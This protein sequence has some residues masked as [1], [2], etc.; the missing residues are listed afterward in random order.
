MK[1]IELDYSKRCAGEPTKGTTGGILIFHRLLRWPP[2]RGSAPDQARRGR[3]GL[4]RLFCG[5]VAQFGFGSNT[6]I[7][8]SSVRARRRAGGHAGG[9]HPQHRASDLGIHLNNSQLRLPQGCLFGTLR[10]PL[11]HPG[12]ICRVLRPSRGTGAGG[13]LH[14]HHRRGSVPPVTSRD[15]AAGG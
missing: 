2:R 14:G 13:A 8:R 10:S 6:P 1:S 9:Q 15:T 5:C 12:R 4:P 11:G 3:A 7:D